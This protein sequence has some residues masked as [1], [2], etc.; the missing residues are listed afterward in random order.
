MIATFLTVGMSGCLTKSSNEPAYQFTYSGTPP[1]TIS[2]V[3]NNGTPVLLFVQTACPVDG[4]AKPCTAG[5]MIIPE[6]ADLQKQFK[7]TD[8]QFEVVDIGHNV[9]SQILARTYAVTA[10]PAILVIRDDGAVARFVQQPLLAIDFAAVQRAIDDARHW[11]ASGNNWVLDRMVRHDK[12]ASYNDPTQKVNAWLEV[13]HSADS[14]TVL[15][16]VQPVK[17]AQNSTRNALFMN[18]TLLSFSTTQN[19]TDYLNS[20]DKNRYSLMS[21]DC[22]NAGVYSG[23]KRVMGHEP[24]TFEM[25]SYTQRPV[26]GTQLRTYSITQYD[27]LVEIMAWWNPYETLRM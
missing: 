3:L 24:Q 11:T 21:T 8:V 14:V 2:D 1:Q 6:F 27:N 4:D 15:K 19:A 7:D 13:W 12:E 5:K 25:W 17:G 22:N 10:T 23:Y 20:L 9:T 26:N 16:T 18:A